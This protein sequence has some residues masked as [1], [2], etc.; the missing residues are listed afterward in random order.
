MS[1]EKI[2]KVFQ[3]GRKSEPKP[4]RKVKVNFRLTEAEKERWEAKAEAVGCGNNLSQFIRLSVERE[5][6]FVLQ[7]TPM[8]MK[9]TYIEL[10]RIGNNINQIATATN[11]SVKMGHQITVD[12]RPEIEALKLLLL[13]VRQL[14]IKVPTDSL[15]THEAE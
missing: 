5:R 10:G 2:K 12:P 1:D 6:T 7:T 11:R 15:P 14:L 8:I 13:E 4:K 3:S 9:Q